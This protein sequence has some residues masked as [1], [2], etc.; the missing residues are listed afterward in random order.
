MAG[1]CDGG[2]EPPGSLKAN[3]RQLRRAGP[4]R[5]QVAVPALSFPLS[6]LPSGRDLSRAGEYS[7]PRSHEVKLKLLERSTS[8]VSDVTLVSR[9]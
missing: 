3:K 2:N 8:C 7:E 6:V 9:G 5:G 4:R 1:L